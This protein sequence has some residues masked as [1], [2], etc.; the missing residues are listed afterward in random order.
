MENFAK[1]VT[2][3]QNGAPVQVRTNLA[4]LPKIYL[5]KF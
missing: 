3:I 2:D 4:A 5:G 1:K